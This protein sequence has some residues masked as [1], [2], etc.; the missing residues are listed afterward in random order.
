MTCHIG[1]TMYKMYVY[2]YVCISLLLRSLFIC[3]REPMTCS[4]S[5]IKYI[6]E[7]NAACW[8]CSFKKVALS[9]MQNIS[10]SFL[11]GEWPGEAASIS[12]ASSS[13]S[14]GNSYSNQHRATLHSW[15]A[16]DHLPEQQP[17]SCSF[18]IF[19][20]LQQTRFFI[21]KSA[22]LIQSMSNHQHDNID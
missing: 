13:S 8:L 18:S 19:I 21:P 12:T 4:A 10:Y 17:C 3:S 22:V 2:L 5:C 14:P 16:V 1:I 20:N 11:V 6:V 15:A 9:S 7:T